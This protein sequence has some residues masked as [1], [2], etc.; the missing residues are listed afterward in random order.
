M[1][2]K[3]FLA[4]RESQIKGLKDK[5]VVLK[6]KLIKIYMEKNIGKE[7]NTSGPKNIRREIAQILSIIREKELKDEEGNKVED[8]SKE[9]LKK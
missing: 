4:L 2:R 5:V 9:S 1:K 8:I 6:E 7:K 3:E